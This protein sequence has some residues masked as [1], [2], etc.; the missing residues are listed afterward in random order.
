[1]GPTTDHP[2]PLLQAQHPQIPCV[3]PSP[4]CV[5][6]FYIRYPLLYPPQYIVYLFRVADSDGGTRQ[7][8]LQCDRMINYNLVRN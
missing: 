1:M 7:A 8:Q 5:L 4:E 2:G 3:L 6:N